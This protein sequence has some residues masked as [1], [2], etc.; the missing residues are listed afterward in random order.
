MT[1]SWSSFEKQKLLQEKWRDFLREEAGFGD[2]ADQFFASGDMAYGTNTDGGDDEKT[3]GL[4]S[5]DNSES[6]L[7]ILR[8]QAPFLEKEQAKL[9]ISIISQV[10]EDEGIMLELSLKGL[11]SE[12]DRVIDAAATENRSEPTSV[13]E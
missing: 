9:L 12:Q 5:A 7:N 13:N 8:Q 11:N 3:F 1:K 2:K 10:A 6:L 4:D